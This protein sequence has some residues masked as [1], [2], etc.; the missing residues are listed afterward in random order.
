MNRDSG[1]IIVKKDNFSIL[2]NVDLSQVR[3]E[4]PIGTG[5]YPID[6]FIQD[7]LVYFASKRIKIPFR[8]KYLT[9]YVNS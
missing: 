6:T 3:H 7:V 4:Y 8:M 1:H 2:L 9:N 5:Q